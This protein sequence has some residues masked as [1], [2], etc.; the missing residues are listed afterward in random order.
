MGRA[1]EERQQQILACLKGQRLLSVS[2]LAA[3]LGCSDATIRRDLRE[4]QAMSH[5]RRFHGAV[6]VN[7]ITLDSLPPERL[8]GTIDER[9]AIAKAVAT[10]L[11]PGQVLGINGGTITPYVA[12]ELVEIGID[13]TVVTNA[14]NIAYK[15]AASRIPIVVVGGVCEFVDYETTGALATESLRDLHLD[16][17]VIDAEG[18]SPEF[19][20]SSFTEAEAW[21]GHAFT[22]QANRVL[23]AVDHGNLGR[24]VPFRMMHWSR[25]DTIASGREGEP[26]MRRWGL[27]L[28]TATAEA[29]VWNL[30]RGDRA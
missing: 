19:G 4:L 23:L 17:A 9:R 1:V 7:H 24:S 28:A 13:V 2:G 3:R 14:V 12:A 5:I 20:V 8:A 21:I 27:E 6:S 11:T 22:Q 16:W 30:P 26:T 15:L 18:V 10:H 29:G 25:V